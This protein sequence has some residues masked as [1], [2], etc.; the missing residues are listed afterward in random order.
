MIKDGKLCKS[1]LFYS[2]CAHAFDPLLC[3][4][5]FRIRTYK[6]LYCL[7]YFSITMYKV[8]F[9]RLT[10]GNDAH[11]EVKDHLPDPRTDYF[12]FLVVRHP[13]ERLASAYY[14]KVYNTTKATKVEHLN[15]CNVC[16]SKMWNK[17]KIILLKIG[18]AVADPGIDRRGG[19]GCR[20]FSRIYTHHSWQSQPLICSRGVRVHSLPENYKIQGL[21]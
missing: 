16:Y 12:R 19:G 7:F 1:K 6:R 8:G 17:K 3:T 9:N 18:Y 11:S 10:R 2:F 21:K 4:P 5:L 15:K 20:S 13:L 14:S